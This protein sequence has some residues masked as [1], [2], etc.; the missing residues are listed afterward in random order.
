MNDVREFEHEVLLAPTATAA[1]KNVISSSNTSHD[2]FG[3]TDAPVPT[4]GKNDSTAKKMDIVHPNDRLLRILGE[5]SV[6]KKL[7][8]VAFWDRDYKVSGSLEQNQ[9]KQGVAEERGAVEGKAARV[10]SGISGGQMLGCFSCFSLTS[11]LQT[12]IQSFIN[13]EP[14]ESDH[15]D[16]EEGDNF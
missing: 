1:T 2:N 8:S 10:G 5:H 9:R 13:D 7:P 15:G 6:K 4:A 3:A 14:E 11:C 12:G 16:S